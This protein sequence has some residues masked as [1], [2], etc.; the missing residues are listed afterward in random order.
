MDDV[1]LRAG[2]TKEV[3]ELVDHQSDCGV[4]A[5]GFGVDLLVLVHLAAGVGNRQCNTARVAGAGIDD[6][7]RVAEAAAMGA[8]CFRHGMI[9]PLRSGDAPNGGSPTNCCTSSWV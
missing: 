1:V 3:R 7:Q 8:V 9:S 5:D 4:Q 2:H 6:H